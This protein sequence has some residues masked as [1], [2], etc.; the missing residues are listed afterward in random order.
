M[1]RVGRYL[2]LIVLLIFVGAAL[3][4]SESLKAR[5]QVGAAVPTFELPTLDGGTIS[6]EDYRGEPVLINFW[7]AWC[8]PCLEE[9]PA[10]DEF[11]RR[12]GD[13]IA[14]LA[15]NERETEA[16]IHRHLNEVAEQGLTM[17][18]PILLDRRGSVG[19]TFKLGGMPETW[20]IDPDGIARRHWVGPVTFEQLQA[21]YFEATGELID[22]ADGGPF[23]TQHVARAVL[24]VPGVNGGLNDVY[25]GGEGGLVRYDVRSGGAAPSDFEREDIDGDTVYALQRAGTV[26]INGAEFDT[27]R[28]QAVTNRGVAGLPAAPVALA[29]DASGRV[30]AWVPGHGLYANEAGDWWHAVPTDLPV[31]M[32]WAGLDADPFTP[33]RWL[34]A[35]AAGL[36]E[37]RDGGRTWRA[38]GVTVRSYAV[39]HDPTEPRRVY[40][41]TDTGV[42]LSEDGGRTAVRIPGSPQRV[43]A[44]LDVV[45]AA[46]GTL[47]LTAVAPNGDVYVSTGTGERWNLIIPRRDM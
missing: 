35:N 14:Y 17:T 23:S 37:S 18:L 16:R 43:L 47:M 2:P 41:A 32:A 34:L 44:A 1:R 4:Y 5:V 27:M 8:P 6:F 22:A 10:H 38:A 7:A 20:V 45:R 30:L 3:I 39:R 11:Y 9:M 25:V 24:A 12:Y 13:R 21:G 28:P 19:E 15:I 40:M 46:D 31:Q 42:W 26:R 36:L 33:D 29:E